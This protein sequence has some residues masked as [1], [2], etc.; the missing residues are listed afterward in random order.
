MLTCIETESWGGADFLTRLGKIR[1][2]I[3]QNAENGVAVLEPK[4]VFDFA[5]AHRQVV[6]SN[7]ANP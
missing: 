4:I 5:Y 7:T 1:A 3:A 2:D 6:F